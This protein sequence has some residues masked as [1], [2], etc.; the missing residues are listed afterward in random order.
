[1]GTKRSPAQFVDW[2]HKKYA[3]ELVST[4]PTEHNLLFWELYNLKFK[5]QYFLPL[6]V[7]LCMPLGTLAL[8]GKANNVLLKQIVTPAERRE[9]KAFYAGHY[10]ASHSKFKE[11]MAPIAPMVIAAVMAVVKLEFLIQTAGVVWA[12]SMSELT[13]G[14]ARPKRAHAIGAHAAL[15]Y[16]LLIEIIGYAV[17]TVR[18]LD[19][20]MQGKQRLTDVVLFWEKIPGSEI[21]WEKLGKEEELEQEMERDRRLE[22]RVSR[23]SEEGMIDSVDAADEKKKVIFDLSSHEMFVKPAAQL[24]EVAFLTSA[25]RHVMLVVPML[26]AY[27]AIL[28]HVYEYK[29]PFH[30]IWDSVALP[31]WLEYFFSLFWRSKAAEF[32]YW[33][34]ET[35]VRKGPE[36]QIGDTGDDMNLRLPSSV[37]SPLLNSAFRSMLKTATSTLGLTSSKSAA[38]REIE[39]QLKRPGLHDLA[40]M[41]EVSFDTLERQ[42][43]RRQRVTR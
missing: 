1:M 14:D 29:T 18:Y 37:N 42:H 13:G 20:F 33:S 38:N 2:L 31:I 11:K 5:L 9:L 15:V 28:T 25:K 17:G 19:L 4:R 27:F 43:Q 30:A 12:W 22:E 16:M 26:A 23:S 21:H 40:K 10:P 8:Q 3:T 41:A 32:F 6:V 36:V 35:V 39:R 7:S 24:F 34:A